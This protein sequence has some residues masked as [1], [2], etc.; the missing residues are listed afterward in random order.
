MQE[1][2]IIWCD[3]EFLS[4]TIFFQDLHQEEVASGVVSRKISEI[5]KHSL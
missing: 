3:Q 4:V 1:V 5:P 2:L